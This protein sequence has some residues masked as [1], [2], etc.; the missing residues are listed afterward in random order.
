[1]PARAVDGKQRQLSQLDGELNLVRL[2][3]RKCRATSDTAQRQFIK[4]QS[5]DKAEL[6][7]FSRASA[8][9]NANSHKW[10]QNIEVREHQITRTPRRT[11][12]AARVHNPAP[13]PSALTSLVFFS[14]HPSLCSVPASLLMS[15]LV[16]VLRVACHR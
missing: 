14:C 7:E 15:P 12:T 13:H 2:Q 11:D 16:S 5:K 10:T 8:H 4:K 9:S 6:Q 1:V 3:L